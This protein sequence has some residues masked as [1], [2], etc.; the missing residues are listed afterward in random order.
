M[1][2]NVTPPNFAPQPE[3]FVSLPPGYGR[4][5]RRRTVTGAYLQILV[6]LVTA[7]MALLVAQWQRIPDFQGRVDSLWWLNT[8]VGWLPAAVMIG[9][10]IN[11]L[12]VSGAIHGDSLRQ[13]DVRRLVANF[14]LWWI[15]S[16]AAAGLVALAQLI[17]CVVV[18]SGA[19]SPLSV[20]D[21]IQFAPPF[22]AASFGSI[23]Y[24]NVRHMLL[25][26]PD[27]LLRMWRSGQL[28]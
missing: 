11:S 19:T 1:T 8:A 6:C 16:L 27:E 21:F 23:L 14:R 28:H 3:E 10:A 5:I 24:F 12:R 15:C 25:R 2:G 7:G 22:L 17:G 26:W 20:R 18:S 13:P 4:Q 9:A